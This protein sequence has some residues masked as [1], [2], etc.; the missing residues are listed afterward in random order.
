MKVSK[1]FQETTRGLATVE[2]PDNATKEEIEDALTECANSTDMLWDGDME[3]SDCNE[4]L[5]YEKE[6]LELD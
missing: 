3:I 4:E 2:V 6:D 5:I 1:W